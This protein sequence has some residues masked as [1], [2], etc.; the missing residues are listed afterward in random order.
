VI[1]YVPF[2]IFGRT[3]LSYGSSQFEGALAISCFAN[4]HIC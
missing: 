4:S 3:G 2:M 1:D